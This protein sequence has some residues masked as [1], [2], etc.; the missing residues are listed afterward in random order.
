MKLI[1][2]YQTYPLH[3]IEQTYIATVEDNKIAINLVIELQTEYYKEMIKE[4]LILSV[5]TVQIEKTIKS[6]EQYYKEVN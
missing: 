4:E 1:N 3:D 2:I 5:F 6:I